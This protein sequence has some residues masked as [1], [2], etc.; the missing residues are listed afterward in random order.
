[1]KL[2]NV[3]VLKADVKNGNGRIYPLAILEKMVMDNKDKVIPGMIGMPIWRSDLRTLVVEKEDLAFESTI[4]GIIDGELQA[5]IVVLDT[6][7]GMLFKD[8]FA[9]NSSLIDNFR[10]AGIAGM[11]QC[12]LD[13]SACII[14]SF[15]LGQ[16]NFVENPA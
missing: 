16:I 13:M 8:M 1:M 12:A 5:D 2:H 9:S 4:V 3:S 10:T 11:S 14:G 15:Q 7:K 6:P